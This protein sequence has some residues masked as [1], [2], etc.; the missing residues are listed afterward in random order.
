MLERGATR[1]KPVPN[2]E[3]YRK[4]ERMYATA[5]VNE[6]YGPTMRVSEGRAEVII[7]VR[8]DFF[9]AGHAVHGAAYFKLLD[10]AAFF[11]ANSLVEDVFVLTVSLNAYL[12][13]PIT[14][15]EMKATGRVVHRSRRIIIA[16]AEV[17]DSEGREIARGSATFMPSNIPLSPEVGYQ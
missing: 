4:L 2:E 15:G 12:I 6:Y 14:E 17:V 11:A 13:R 5:P 9:H 1:G 3:H 10:D 8:R 7:Q 16:E